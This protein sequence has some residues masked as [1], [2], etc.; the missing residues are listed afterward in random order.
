MVLTGINSTLRRSVFSHAIIFS[1][2]AQTKDVIGNNK[3]K[4]MKI[5]FKLSALNSKFLVMKNLNK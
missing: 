1:N 3:Y 4:L 2:I 5:Y